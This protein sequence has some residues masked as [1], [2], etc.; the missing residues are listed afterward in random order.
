[1]VGNV[2]V[3]ALLVGATA[4]LDDGSPTHPGPDGV[5]AAAARAGAT[6]L[7]TSAG[8]LAS[9]HKHKHGLEPGRDL[10]ALRCVLS[11]GSP[12][13]AVPAIPRT[14]TG[15]RLELPVK[16]LLRGVSLE[17]AVDPGVVDDPA[18]LEAFRRP[19]P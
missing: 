4:V 6:H 13:A 7:G 11:T 1:M 16:G 15:K 10:T 2:V 14:L 17:D 8:Y 19:A 3:G 9:S 5:W 18:I 12:L